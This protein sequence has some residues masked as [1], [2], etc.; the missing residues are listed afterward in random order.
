MHQDCVGQAH[1]AE[2]VMTSLAFTVQTAKDDSC[3]AKRGGACALCG[4][5]AGLLCMTGV[6]G[7]SAQRHVVG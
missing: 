5:G 7:G 1:R 2:S 3:R 6:P 4:T